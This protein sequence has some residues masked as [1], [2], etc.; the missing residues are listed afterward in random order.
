MTCEA[1]AS[2][3][4]RHA[5]LRLTM[6]RLMLLTAVMHMG[7]HIPARDI[8]HHLGRVTPQTPPSTVYRVLSALRDARLV[9]ETLTAGG[10]TVYEA[11]VESPH[12]HLE[13]RSCGSIVDV[14]HGYFGDI[15]PRL[16]RDYGFEP[17]L[18]HVSLKGRCAACLRVPGQRADPGATGTSS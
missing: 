17:D 15:V 11:A 5:G 14:D 9:Y 18:D 7:G 13:C 12:H 10:E 6:P 8:V 2:S 16:A 4:I 1:R 3:A